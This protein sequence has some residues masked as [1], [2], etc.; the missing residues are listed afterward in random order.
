MN[1]GACKFLLQQT[2]VHILVSFI[3]P[4]FMEHE[5]EG[6]RPRGR[7]KKTCKE[8]VRQDCQARKL[9]KEDAMDC[10]KWRKVIK[11]ERWSGWVWV[12]ECFF[13]YWPTRVVP[14]QRPLNGRCCCCQCGLQC[15]NTV[16]WATRRASG[17]QKKLSGR[18]LAWLSAWSEMQTC[19]WPSWCHCH[20]LYLSGTGLPGLS[21]TKGH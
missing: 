4:K 1:T 17:Q 3:Q 21:R 7:P 13:W 18:M 16:G 11:E 19:I 15:F 8:V 9:N 14:D 20:S 10:C 12:G 6:L 5:V 2:Y